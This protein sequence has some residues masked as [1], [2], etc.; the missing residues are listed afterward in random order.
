MT[1]EKMLNLVAYIRRDRWLHFIYTTDIDEGGVSRP[2]MQI[3]SV[4]HTPDT[5]TKA[6]KNC[7]RASLDALQEFMSLNDIDYYTATGSLVGTEDALLG[8]GR[9]I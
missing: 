4:L 7:V 9:C 8:G 1:L 5:T 2:V 3:S 6:T